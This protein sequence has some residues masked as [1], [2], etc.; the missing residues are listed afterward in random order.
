MAK[1]AADV[2]IR[3]KA[4]NQPG[5]SIEIIGTEP[6]RCIIRRGGKRSAKT[7]EAITYT[8]LGAMIAR[9]AKR[10]VQRVRMQA[11][12]DSMRQS[13]AEAGPRNQPP[14]PSLH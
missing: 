9:W 8:K 10:D 12:K 14:M 4:R 5:Q 13:R 1:I 11:F 7:P 3:F 2:T 6:G